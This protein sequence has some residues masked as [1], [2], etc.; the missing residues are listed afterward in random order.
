MKKRLLCTLLV[1]TMSFSQA[2]VAG[3]ATV[4]DNAVVTDVAAEDETAGLQEAETDGELEA[5]TVGALFLNSP[6]RIEAGQECKIELMID[7][8]TDYSVRF[9]EKATGNPSLTK[10]GTSSS[11]SKIVNISI[12]KDDLLAGD[13]VIQ[14]WASREDYSSAVAKQLPVYTNDLAVRDSIRKAVNS[15]MSDLTVE[16]AVYTGN[17][18]IPNVILK[19]TKN[20]TEYTLRKDVDFQIE[21]VSAN[22]KDMGKAQAKVT[23]IG[24]YA[25]EITA[26]FDI[27]PQAP[28]IT[29]VTCLNTSSVKITWEKSPN[30]KGYYIERKAADGTF[31]NV[32]QTDE[33]ATSYIDTTAGLEVGQTYY[34]RVMA[35]ATY[36]V[37]TDAGTEEKQVYSTP[38]EIGVAVQILPAA[39]E[40]VSLEN[41]STTR[42]KLT[43]K[44]SEEADGYRVF[45]VENG[46]LKKI[47]DIKSADTTSLTIK[48]LSCGYTYQYCVKAYKK[49]AAGTN[50]YSNESKKIKAKAAPA[51]PQLVSVTSVKATENEVKWKKVSGATGYYVYRKESGSTKWKKI[52]NVQNGNTVTYNDKKAVTGKKYAYTVKAYTKAK[53]NKKTKT[54]ISQYDKKGITG[55]AVP[56]KTIFTMQ[57]NKKGVLITIANSEGATGYYLYRKKGDEKWIKRDVPAQSG[58]MTVYLDRDITAATEYQ[59][60]IV[61]YAQTGTSRVKG[62][63]SDTQKFTTK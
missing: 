5:E 3:A 62:T 32:G 63:K 7:P 35:S 27:V 14:Y 12:G 11:T 8:G 53:V 39:P 20:G 58:D 41:V 10:N 51:M 54:I 29:G 43:W 33:K 40:I 19:E 15:N 6:E 28:A 47:K 1:L 17:A 44:K 52:A 34:Y 38:N 22:K 42:L 57:Q 55:K 26:D 16:N 4:S 61:P 59:Y 37:T 60:Y 18:V 13:Y 45:K 48:K 2:A 31:A 23:G 46:Q 21:V 50:I 36:Q 24:N 25:G 56:A 30:A 9:V 49:D